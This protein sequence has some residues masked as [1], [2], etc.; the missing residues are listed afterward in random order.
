M[1]TSLFRKSGLACCVLI[2]WS[3][4]SAESRSAEIGVSDP[5]KLDRG[6]G[7]IIGPLAFSLDDSC[8]VAV[9][10]TTPTHQSAFVWQGKYVI[11]DLKQRER[12]EVPIPRGSSI[13]NVLSP[14]PNAD[15]D[16]PRDD[17]LYVRGPF[18][19]YKITLTESGVAKRTKPSPMEVGWLKSG[20]SL[21]SFEYDEKDDFEIELAAASPDLTALAIVARGHGE[22]EKP[23]V[24]VHGVEIRG[25]KIRDVWTSVGR[26]ELWGLSPPARKRVYRSDE[27]GF[28][29]AAFSA[30]GKVAF[31]GAGG[32]PGRNPHGEIHIWRVADA[33]PLQTMAVED[34]RLTCL[35]FSPDGETLVT[36]GFGKGEDSRLIWWDFAS[37]E[38]KGEV[39]LDLPAREPGRALGH[40]MIHDCAYSPC[41]RV[42][43]VAVGSWHRKAEWGEVR[44]IDVESKKVVA[45]PWEK[46]RLW[47]ENVA[48]S[49]DGTML[50]ASTWS[51]IMLWR[52]KLNDEEN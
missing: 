34:L 11:F 52:I 25:V 12:K 7:K 29:D 15:A 13:Y 50:A 27:V 39:Q 18:P 20:K 10:Q 5:Q 1:G 22:R 14:A 44:L 49:H 19:A 46:A 16:L 6:G 32:D 41:G 43:A 30:D 37:G 24:K 23:P 47:C 28:D 35:A 3:C 9:R 17:V 2:L 40:L 4:F 33:E 26:T 45:T 42:V 21:A 8:L 51:D 48:F 31:G 38:R 36:G